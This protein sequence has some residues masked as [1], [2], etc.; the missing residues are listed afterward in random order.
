MNANEIQTKINYWLE[1][2]FDI[3]TKDAIRLLQKTNPEALVDAFYTN[4]SFGTGGMRGL[5]GVGTNRMNIY[6]VRRAT[7]GLANYLTKSVG[8]TISVAIGY[9]SRHNS[10]LFAQEASR[11]LAGNG[12]TVYLFSEIRPTPLVSFACRTL[13]CSSAIMITASH[14]PPLYNGFKVYWSDGAQVLA[15]HDA[16]IIKEVEALNDPDQVKLAPLTSPLIHMMGEE[17]DEAYL[18]AIEP[19]QLWPQMCH[20]KGSGLKILYSSLHGTG[21]AMV[22]KALMR[23]GFTN[24]SFVDEQI[25]PDGDFPTC[26]KPN[27]EEK[28]ALNLG[29][30]KL[31]HTGADIFIATDPD[32]DRLGV[33]VRHGEKAVPLTGNQMI[34]LAA[35]YICQADRLPSKAAFIKTIVTTELFRKIVE[36]HNAAC[37]D[38]LTGFKYIAEKIREWENSPGSYTFVFGGEESYGCLLGSVVRDKDAITASCLIAEIALYAKEKGKTLIDLLND[39]YLRYGTYAEHLVSVDY[40]ETMEGKE[41]MKQ[42]MQHLRSSCHGKILQYPISQVKDLLK[43]SDLP[44][45]DVVILEL[46]DGSKAIVRPS[47]TEPRIKIYVLSRETGESKA[48]A[49]GNELK[50]LLLS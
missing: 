6:T 21:S 20:E 32:C 17:V 5:M 11:T 9:D 16:G 15:P 19:L 10:K 2:N 25:I 46:E 48:E 8:S 1:K 22:P 27:P 43:P 42:A 14:N 29:I 35:E 23:F 26:K 31:L 49:I 28:A 13:H 44:L 24:L 38:V 30:D 3:A 39:L 34:S 47:G 7:Q 45:S 4:L 36:A 12:I 40:E 18:K 41:R 50:I 33:V 37:F